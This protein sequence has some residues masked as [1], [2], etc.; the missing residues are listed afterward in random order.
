MADIYSTKHI[1]MTDGERYKLLVKA[2]TGIPLYYPTLY[3]TSQIRGCG[4]SVSTIQSFIT[5]LKVLLRWSAHYSVDMEERF[6]RKEFLT[7]QEVEA[8]RDFCKKP[9]KEK[10]PKSPT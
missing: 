5:S 7:L 9:L 2:A 1:I 3:I 4:Q 10:E 8:L 6:I